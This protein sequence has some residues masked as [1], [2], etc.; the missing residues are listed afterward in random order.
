LRLNS[1]PELTETG[2]LKHYCHHI[3]LW[4]MELPGSQTDRVIAQTAK[5]INAIAAQNLWNTQK[6]TMQTHV[7]MTLEIPATGRKVNTQE[8]IE[9][10]KS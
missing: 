7:V 10:N 5:V 9:I 6:H 4:T 8:F 2:K 3:P 1:F